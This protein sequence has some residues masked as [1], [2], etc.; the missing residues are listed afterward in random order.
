MLEIII[1]G[2]VFYVGYNLG[3]IVTSWQL[4]DLIIRDAKREG[5][6]D[7]NLN[8]IDERVP[9]VH[10]L[11]VEKQNN[12]LYLY[13][14]EANSF[15]CQATTIEELAKLAKQYKNIKYAAVMDVEGDSVYTF[16]DGKVEIK[17]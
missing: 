1:L 4:R 5:I 2:F 13:D 11:T 3:Q 8:F 14:Q 17:L 6:I 12:I 9:N 10:K 15:V 7:D 16:V